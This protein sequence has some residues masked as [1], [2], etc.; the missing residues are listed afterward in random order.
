MPGEL[1]LPP[2]P[3]E[4]VVVPEQLFII[5]NPVST[6]A[7][8]A[9]RHISAIQ[10]LHP[11]IDLDV[12]PTVYDPELPADENVANNQ[13]FIFEAIA[14][15]LKTTKPNKVWLGVASGD[16]FLNAVA[17]RFL[18]DSTPPEVRAVPI[19]PIAGGNGN[20]VSSMVHGYIGKH[21][22]AWRFHKAFTS[23]VHPLE[24]QL[25]RDNAVVH[26]K[27]LGYISIGNMISPAAKAIS[28]DRG[29]G[30]LTQK[31][32]EKILA[33]REVL[34]A[35]PFRMTENGEK[36]EIYERIFANGPRMAKYLHWPVALRESRF[37]DVAIHDARLTRLIPYSARIML[38]Q[39]AGREVTAQDSVTFQVNSETMLEVDGEAFAVAA[40]T[41]VTVRRSSQSLQIVHLRPAL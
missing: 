1:L 39:V 23:S 6:H 15:R 4:D 19:L 5:R 16:G 33:S 37:L 10:K 9:R 26:R 8:R 17:D 32:R 24:I 22:P 38:G 27:G 29:H 12:F 25:A 40:D 21:R 11:S 18:H 31:V 34:A 2:H 20:D 3:E 13:T 28:N 7:A 14:Q 36:S 41:D 30:M 35:T